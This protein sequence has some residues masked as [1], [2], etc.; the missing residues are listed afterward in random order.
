MIAKIR[1]TQIETQTFEVKE[2]LIEFFKY[3]NKLL[4][5]KVHRLEKTINDNNGYFVVKQLII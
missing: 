2:M 1:D 5:Q 3:Y 4:L